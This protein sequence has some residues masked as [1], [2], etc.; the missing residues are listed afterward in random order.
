M[1]ALLTSLNEP[2]MRFV[3]HSSIS[4]QGL[5]ESQDLQLLHWLSSVP[6]SFIVDVVYHRDLKGSFAYIVLV[7]TKLINAESFRFR[8]RTF[9]KEH[10]EGRCSSVSDDHRRIPDDVCREKYELYHWYTSPISARLDIHTRSLST[11]TTEP[12]TQIH[13][14]G[15]R[16]LSYIQ[17]GSYVFLDEAL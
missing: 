13:L 14:P 3:D 16:S 7:D 12:H 5:Q 4:A 17:A 6:L 9:S 2:I 1:K 8:G 10:P 11:C 15:Q